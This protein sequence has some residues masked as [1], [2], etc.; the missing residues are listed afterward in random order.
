MP[1]A[2]KQLKGRDIVQLAR[3]AGWRDEAVITA[4]AI[5]RAESDYYTAAWNDQNPDGSTDYG[6]W[7]INSV[8]IGA[9]VGGR[10]V[11][12]EA[13]KDPV[14]NAEVAHDLVYRGRS[15]SFRA[16]ASYGVGGRY[17]QYR[18]SAIVSQAN[19]WREKYGLIPPV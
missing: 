17:E 10:T 8:H 14:F 16:W 11:T 15:Y 6:L 12:A 7:Q 2:G 3:G 9:V 5:C 4:V 19:Y 18:E 13:L 1:L